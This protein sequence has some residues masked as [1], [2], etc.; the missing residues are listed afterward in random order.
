VTLAASLVGLVAVRHVDTTVRFLIVAGAIA[1]F[2]PYALLRLVLR[3]GAAAMLVRFL[4]FVR[5]VRRDPERILAKA[6]EI[7]AIVAGFWRQ[8]PGA[9]LTVL[10]LQIAARIVSGAGLI[11]TLRLLGLPISLSNGALLYAAMNTAD[12]LITL[13]PTR[14]GVSEGAAFGIF[15]LFGLPPQIGVIMYVV[16]RIR[17][18]AT[19]GVLAP[20]AFLPVHAERASPQSSDP[21]PEA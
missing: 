16:F 3:R 13:V 2:A 6:L 18:L 21:K 11:A 20:F 10:F 12:L 8:R 1:A 4:R 7:D 17:S 19:T 14:L 15:K 5:I 9:F